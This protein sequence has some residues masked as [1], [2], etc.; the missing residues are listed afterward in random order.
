MPY[1]DP[2]SNILSSTPIIKRTSSSSSSSPPFSLSLI[3]TSRP[4]SPSMVIDTVP[5][6]Y[7]TRIPSHDLTPR[8]SRTMTVSSHQSSIDLS[9]P[10]SN[11]VEIDTLA[12]NLS[13]TSLSQSNTSSSSPTPPLSDY[14]DLD[15]SPSASSV[16]IRSLASTEEDTSREGAVARYRAGLYNYTHELYIQAKLASAFAQKKRNAPSPSQFGATQS[17]M[18]RMAAKKALARRLNG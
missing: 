1:V 3:S 6:P 14:T 11:D 17:G 18:E 16:S 9:S 15:T 10:N 8:P 13:S 5:R 4:S 2:S 12:D 7:P